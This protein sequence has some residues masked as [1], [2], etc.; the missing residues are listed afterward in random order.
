MA[1]GR[2]K[3]ASESPGA[4]VVRAAIG[5]TELKYL[6]AELCA[7]KGVRDNLKMLNCRG[8]PNMRRSC[9]VAIYL[10]RH[11]VDNP[12]VH[13]RRIGGDRVGI[14]TPHEIGYFIEK[15]DSAEYPELVDDRS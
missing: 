7:G 9:P 6:L 1:E 15:F 14:A 3:K 5:A 11:G 4:A 12:F 2:L 13:E 8:K 10:R